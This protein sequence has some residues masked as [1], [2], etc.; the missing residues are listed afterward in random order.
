MLVVRKCETTTTLQMFVEL[1]ISQPTKEK[2]RKRNKAN[3]MSA[4]SSRKRKQFKRSKKFGVIATRRTKL[5]TT[6]H[7][8]RL[9]RD[10]RPKSEQHQ[11]SQNNQTKDHHH[12]E[13]HSKRTA[14]EQKW[15]ANY[16]M[17]KY[18]YKTR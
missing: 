1:I 16:S 3:I 11:R 2:E 13:V 9:T 12:Q 15:S 4:I 5:L 7:N 14:K 6:C 17:L 10:S 8:Q 18:S